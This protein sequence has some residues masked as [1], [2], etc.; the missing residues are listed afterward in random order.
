MKL[1]ARYGRSGAVWHFRARC[2]IFQRGLAPLVRFGTPS[3]GLASSCKT[4]T[5]IEQWGRLLYGRVCVGGGW[6]NIFVNSEIALLGLWI[7]VLDEKILWNRFAIRIV[8]S[9]TS[10][11]SVNYEISLIFVLWNVNE[12]KLRVVNW[13]C[14]IPTYIIFKCEI[15]VEQLL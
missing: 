2:G 4:G 12:M 10:Q 14:Q 7:C 15:R 11:D 13:T 9:F 8:I 3:R 1:H 5:A 6:G